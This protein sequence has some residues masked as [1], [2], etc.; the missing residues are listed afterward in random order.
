MEMSTAFYAPCAGEGK[1]ILQVKSGSWPNGMKLGKGK[2]EG[3]CKFKHL[4]SKSVDMIRGHSEGVSRF[5]FTSSSVRPIMGT[6][7]AG[8][9]VAKSRVESTGCLRLLPRKRDVHYGRT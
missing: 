2:G 8:S 6:S 4:Q 5:F 9:T 3:Y 1:Q 7:P